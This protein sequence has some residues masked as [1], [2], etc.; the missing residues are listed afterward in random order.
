[1][2]SDSRRNSSR[3]TGG[4]GPSTKYYVFFIKYYI[5]ASTSR[6]DSEDSSR[7][8]RAQRGAENGVGNGNETGNS[9]VVVSHYNCRPSVRHD[10]GVRNSKKSGFHDSVPSREKK[11]GMDSC[12]GEEIEA[13][14]D[15]ASDRDYETS[16]EDDDE[17][18]TTHSGHRQPT[19]QNSTFTSDP[20]VME[21]DYIPPLVAPR[22]GQLN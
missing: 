14:D 16:I 4:T 17:F 15:A 3:R 11:N 12:R 1:M 19:T 9:D 2:S 20:E 6:L 22:R 10:D 8:W 21:R 5:F 18:E 7:Y 13:T